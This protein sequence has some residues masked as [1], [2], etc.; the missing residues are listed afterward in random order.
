[1]NGLSNLQ[2]LLQMLNP[3][4]SDQEYVFCTFENISDTELATLKPTGTFQEPEG[5]ALILEKQVAF[6]HGFSNDIVFRMITLQVHSS[7]DAV[8]LTAAVATV[9]AKRNISANIV[10]GYYHDHIFVPADRAEDAMEALRQL[11]EEAKS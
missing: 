1:M 6:E 5:L 9:L 2:Q 10:A 3:T 8:G 4:L 7:L 11:S